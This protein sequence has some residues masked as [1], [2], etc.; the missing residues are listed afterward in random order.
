[1]TTGAPLDMVGPHV[2]A[3]AGRGDRAAGRP[4]RLGRLGRLGAWVRLTKPRVIELLLVTTVPPMILAKGG[5]PSVGLIVGVLV[6][7]A[8]AAGGANT[9]N[10]YL[11]RERD[12]LMARTHDRPLATGEIRPRYGL[13][14]GL[15]L[16]VIA[17]A[18]LWPAANLLAACLTIT[19][20]LF[21]I[22]VYTIWLK[23]R[24]VQNIVIG[25][26]AGAVPV[27][28]GWAAVTERIGA[29]SWVL[30]AVVFLW[31]PA[32]FW[33]LAIRYRDDY[34]NAGFPMLPVVRGIRAATNQIV[35]YACLTAFASA[36]LGV[37]VDVGP[38]YVGAVIVLGAAFILLA[39]GL[40]SNPSSARAIRF[41]AMSNVYLLAVF[42]A[43]AIDVYT[44]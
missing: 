31:T 11:E 43:V 25:G 38:L 12:Q 30:F 15:A 21:Y 37:F 32:H 8:L 1:M 14:F 16:N 42:A 10:S 4:G 9:I 3:P 23:P 20:T 40:R 26:A 6:G 19:A 18:V 29:P 39:L 22:F 2:A 5:T 27:L 17:F 41:F 24:T 36:L 34:A 35:V 44:R 33:A 28:V 13:L 7:G